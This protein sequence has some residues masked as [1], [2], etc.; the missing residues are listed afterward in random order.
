MREKD[1]YLESGYLNID[2]IMST[3]KPFVF[4]TG[5]RA[6][7]K[8]Y[9]LLKWIKENNKKF[10]FL[11]RTETQTSVLGCN[12]FSPFGALNHDLGW[13]VRTFTLV[14]NI[15]CFCDAILDDSDKWVPSGE[16]LGYLLALSTFANLR[17]FSAQD[18]DIVVFDEFCPEARERPIKDEAGAFENMYETINRN[19]ELQGRPPLVCVCLANS[20][21]LSSPILESRGLTRIMSSLAKSGKQIHEDAKTICIRLN[22]SPISERKAGTAQYM[23]TKNDNFKKMALN[24]QFVN[25]YTDH[26]RGNQNLQ[27]YIPLCCCG[28]LSFYRHKHRREYY[29]TTIKYGSFQAVYADTPQDRRRWLHRYGFLYKH[30]LDGLMY[31]SESYTVILFERYNKRE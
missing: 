31:F 7:G 3:G 22:S 12:D 2:A 23:A 8:T 1:L 4:I 17:G 21:D 9:G 19:R 28:Q 10:I 6:T 26:I 20:N 5:G 11:R 13:A 16:P 14:K 18:V 27:E 15:K 30:F 24:N 25:D 29:C